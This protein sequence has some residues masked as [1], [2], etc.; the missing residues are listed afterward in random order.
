MKFLLM[1]N[2]C[3]WIAD[4]GNETIVSRFLRKWQSERLLTTTKSTCIQVS[5][6]TSRCVTSTLKGEEHKERAE[7]TFVQDQIKRPK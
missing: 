2:S 5:D 4:L 7:M 6:K 1:R 3:S